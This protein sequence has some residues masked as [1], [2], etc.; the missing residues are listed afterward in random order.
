MPSYEAIFTN[1]IS[2]G[3]LI[4]IMIEQRDVSLRHDQDLLENVSKRILMNR[5]CSVL[6]RRELLR[7]ILKVFCQ[8]NHLAHMICFV[9]R[10]L[11]NQL[12]V[13]SVGPCRF[14]WVSSIK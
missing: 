10:V 1:D 6:V 13:D 5:E 4:E 8:G 11:K 9:D 12:D 3:I 14:G 7:L 2:H